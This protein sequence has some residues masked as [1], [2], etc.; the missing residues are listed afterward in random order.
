MGVDTQS[1]R[2]RESGEVLSACD[3]SAAS[4][5]PKQWAARLGW[6]CWWAVRRGRTALLRTRELCWDGSRVWNG[7]SSEMLKS[8]RRES[9]PFIELQYK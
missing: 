5:L 1:V 6:W 4:G 3:A 9:Y 7:G 2:S 8:M